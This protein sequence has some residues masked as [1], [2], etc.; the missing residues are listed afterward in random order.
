MPENTSDFFGSTAVHSRDPL[1]EEPAWGGGKA[2]LYDL[3]LRAMS[4]YN[5]TQ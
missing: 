5:R 3:M 1:L 4:L 2:S